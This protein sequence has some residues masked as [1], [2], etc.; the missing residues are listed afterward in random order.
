MSPVSFPSLDYLCQILQ[1]T[2]KHV[3]TWS[4]GAKSS[5]R[6]AD[7]PMG[8]TDQ[9]AYTSRNSH[10][11]VQKLTSTAQ[12]LT[13]TAQKFISSVQKFAHNLQK[14]T[15]FSTL[16]YTSSQADMHTGREGGREGEGC[17]FLSRLLVLFVCLVCSSAPEAKVLRSWNERK[18]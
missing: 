4:K 13:S 10:P 17:K 7:G 14:L 5:L 18:K 15:S 16:V 8:L 6:W 11:Q 9:C 1:H 3:S 12:K 2:P